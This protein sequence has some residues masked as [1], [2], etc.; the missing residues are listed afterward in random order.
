[1][2][3]LALSNITKRFPGVI[4]LDSVDFSVEGGEIRAL[5]GEN[6]AGKSTLIKVIG[7]VYAPEQGLIEFEGDKKV[8]ASPQVVRDAG[9]HIIYQELVVFPELTVAENIVTHKQPRNVLGFLDR[10]SIRSRADEILERLGA[11]VSPDALVKD[12]SVADQQMIEIARALNSD[13]KVFIF[14]EPTAV[15]GGK[16]VS[17]LFDIIRRLKTQGVAVVFVSHRIDEVFEIADTVSVLKD[18]RL[19][20]TEP[21][22]ELT[23]G[24]LVSMMIGRQLADIYPP[25]KQTEFS[26]DLVLDVRN[27]KADASSPPTSLQVHRGEIVGL[28]GMVGSGRSELAHAI[29]GSVDNAGGTIAIGGTELSRHSPSDSIEAGAGFLT[30][31]RKNEGL[32]MLLDVAANI[33]A[34]ILRSVSRRT[35][36]DRKTE[37]RIARDQIEKYGIIASGP[38]A[39]VLNLSGGNQQKVLLSRWVLAGREFLILD[40]PTRGVDVGAK[41]EIYRIIREIADSGLGI[42]MISSELP[43]LIGMCER[44]IVMR[45]GEVSGELGGKDI[46]EAEILKLAVRSVPFA[47]AGK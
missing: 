9:I 7:G 29:F 42:L 15:L 4:S 41:V 8:W 2:S 46:S 32:F 13:A 19:V 30:E 40:E 12:V 16:E 17:L 33:S 27:I 14:D 10:N 3:I 23:H 43:E 25:K 5:V 24:D 47:V 18:G 1:M 45:E 34:P 22:S 26:T 6:G 35:M 31:D 21:T 38:D 28:A 44:V 39:R 20:G 37:N 11:Q 36:L